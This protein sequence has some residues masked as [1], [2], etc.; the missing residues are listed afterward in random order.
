MITTESVNPN[1]ILKPGLTGLIKL[2][3]FKNQNSN[4]INSYY[5][6]NQSLS[7]DIEIILKSLFKI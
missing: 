7:F 1:N 3:K 6:R 2:Q 4:V 5:I